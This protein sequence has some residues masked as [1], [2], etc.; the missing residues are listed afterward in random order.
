MGDPAVQKRNMRQKIKEQGRPTDGAE[1][2]KLTHCV[3]HCACLERE[4]SCACARG[5]VVVAC[6][7]CDQSRS[8]GDGARII[9]A[10][11]YSCKRGLCHC[12]LGAIARSG[13]ACTV[14][15]MEQWNG[16]SQQNKK[17]QLPPPRKMPAPR[18]VSISEGTSARRLS[19]SNGFEA[20][21][22]E[23]LLPMSE[24]AAAHMRNVRLVGRPKSPSPAT[25]V[26]VGDDDDDDDDDDLPHHTMLYNDP[27]PAVVRGHSGRTYG[28]ERARRCCLRPHQEPRRTAIIIVESMAFESFVLLT[29][30]LNMVT[31]AM[32]SPTAIVQESTQGSL[33]QLDFA[34]L[35]VY[36]AELAFKVLAYGVHDAKGSFLHDPWSMGEGLIVVISW[37]PYVFPSDTKGLS[38]VVRAFRALRV[39]IALIILPGMK[40]L[41]TATVRSIPALANVF[42]LAAFLLLT[43]GISGVQFFKGALHKRCATD[44]IARLPSTLSN[45]ERRN[46]AAEFDTGILCGRDPALCIEQTTCFTFDSNPGEDTISFDSVMASFFPLGTTLVLDSWSESMYMLMD[47]YSVNAWIYFCSMVILGGFIVLQLFLAVISE[48]FARIENERKA[49]LAERQERRT[50]RRQSLQGH[51][52]IKI[53]DGSAQN[54]APVDPAYSARKP[55]HHQGFCTCGGRREGLLRT[56]ESS[57]FSNLSLA[58]VIFNVF[59]MCLKY[60]GQPEWYSRILALLGDGLTWVFI[61]EMAL[62][63]MAFGCIGYWS[64]RW[65]VLDGSL[66]SVSLVEIVLGAFS[67]TGSSDSNLSSQLRMLRMLRIVRATRLLKSWKGMVKILVAFVK[68]IP[69]VGN[70]TILMGVI[71]FIMSILGMQLFGGS[72]LREVS[73]EHFDTFPAAMI[74]TLNVFVGGYVEVY[75]NCNRFAGP[76]VT[77]MYFTPALLIGFLTLLNLFIG[78]LLQTFSNDDEEQTPTARNASEAQHNQPQ[79]F[80]IDAKNES[81]RAVASDEQRDTATAQT[82]H[83]IIIGESCFGQGPESKLRRAAHAFVHHDMF[84]Y[85]ILLLIVVSSLCLTIDTPRLDPHGDLKQGLERI[86]LYL[87]VAFTAECALKIFAQTFGPYFSSSWNVMDLLIVGASLI[88]LFASVFPSLS[89]LRALRILRVLR[90]LRLLS[91]NPGMKVVIETLAATLPAVLNISGIVL[92][93]MLVHAIIGMRLFM[94]CFGACT[95]PS[96]T[97]KALCV[98]QE[99]LPPPLDRRE[100]LRTGLAPSDMSSSAL[101]RNASRAALPSPFVPPASPKPHLSTSVQKSRIWRHRGRE[102]KGGTYQGTRAEDAPVAWMNPAAGSFDNLGS[103]MLALF[104]ATT[105]DNMPDLLWVGMDSKGVDVAPR[106]TDF[107]PFAIYFIVWIFIGSFMALNLFVGAIVDNFRSIRAENDGSALMTPGQK[108]WVSMM[109]EVRDSVPQQ[110]PQPPD[111]TSCFACFTPCRSKV[112]NVVHSKWFDVFM[113][114]MIFVNVTV[115]ACDHYGLEAELV[116][117]PVYV[118]ANEL[119]LAVYVIEFALKL[120]GY[121]PVAYFLNEWCRFEFALLVC[122]EAEWALMHGHVE[123]PQQALRLLRVFK[124]L[125]IL[126]LFQGSWTKDLR[127]LLK[128]LLLTVPALINVTSVLALVVFIYATLGV[129][130]FTYVKLGSTLNEHANFVSFGQACLL[131]FQALTGDRWSY[132]MIDAMIGPGEGCDPAAVP[133][134]CGSWIALPYFV[135]FQI[136]GTFIFLNL[137]VAIVL[138]NFSSLQELQK[139]RGMREH[140]HLATPEDV[141][142]FIEAWSEFDPRADGKLSSELLPKLIASLPKPLGT[143]ENEP[144]AY[145]PSPDFSKPGSKPP[146]Q[147]PP[148]AAHPPSPEHQKRN[149]SREQVAIDFCLSLKSV[150]EEEGMVEFRNV[151]EAMVAKGFESIAGIG[152]PLA[153][154]TPR[155]GAYTN[156]MRELRDHG[157]ESQVH[158]GQRQPVEHGRHLTALDA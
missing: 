26:G 124:V 70:L 12:S 75:Q 115:L 149:V 46:A 72:G 150:K 47:A 140:V 37:V 104:V 50:I 64:D 34:F 82:A 5:V 148:N 25:I 85:V 1:K 103:A 4:T 92:A 106:R 91:R 118:F 31:M 141:D 57:W 152:L 94:G 151:L 27:P 86:N 38:S 137:I 52:L 39:M 32:E 45:S 105:G 55:V 98:P 96:I 121:G 21:D 120:V 156:H 125:R 108:L 49:M 15:D 145:R 14:K 74:T 136:V 54:G 130:L 97:I 112:F 48:S 84:E 9:A 69:Q 154:N 10:R 13:A 95:D 81:V 83:P 146:S 22:S 20:N 7:S 76:L 60:H 17:R 51:E 71:M 66:V 28:L 100:L 63:L 122:S 33:E 61:I 102:L 111:S 123:V 23:S 147:A 79:P 113:S 88:S 158:E 114:G 77:A 62:K 99:P 116:W 110:I 109:R 133:T 90:P 16:L 19:S 139:A 144:W 8:G 42:S 127:E 131:L 138:E 129:R 80:Q 44:G 11:C 73:R 29:I 89:F 126:R 142:Q 157:S 128:V 30:L 53:T 153:R 143:Y 65:N 35:I 40:A 6:R 117:W 134:D 43:M 87:T 93:L 107:S 58:F 155:S 101:L 132:A 59:L 36:T 68:A 41:L 78:I 135:S 18:K 67:S 24:R 119:F 3:P 56:V 2:R